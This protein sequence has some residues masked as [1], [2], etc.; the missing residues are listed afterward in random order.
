MAEKPAGSSG[1]RPG[2]SST[3]GGS[4]IPRDRFVSQVVPDPANL[5]AESPHVL[6]GY[7]G[8]S[9]EAGYTRV[10][11]GSKLDDYADVRDDDILHYEPSEGG[12]EHTLWVRSGAQ[13]RH[14]RRGQAK[15]EAGSFLGGPLLRDYQGTGAGGAAGGAQAVTQLCTW[16]CPTAPGVC[17]PSIGCP[18][19][20]AAAAGPIGVTGWLGCGVTHQLGCPRTS[21]C[22]PTHMP[23][24]PSTS[25]CPPTAMLGC[26]RTSTCPPTYT[27]GCPTDP[28]AATMCFICPPITADCPVEQAA[29][30]AAA[31]AVPAAAGAAAITTFQQCVP[32]HTL[33]TV[34]TQIG[35]RTH[36]PVQCTHLFH[37]PSGTAATVCTQYGCPG[38]ATYQAGC[39]LGFTCTYVGCPG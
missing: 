34:C 13:V 5:D 18:G 20:E 2:A 10:Y 15:G 14:G 22:P 32:T 35:C 33:A 17:P 29:G 37:C 24:C 3:G 8:D 30:G 9:D 19:A 11:C 21:T 28:T 23:G 6:R 38:P 25:T 26:P 16:I 7:V 36:Y 27:P 1:G 12:E 4:R 31:R 39:T